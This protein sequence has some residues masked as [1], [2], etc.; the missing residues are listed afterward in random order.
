MNYQRIKK[1]NYSILQVKD[2]KV[3][4]EKGITAKNKFIA[5]FQ[6]KNLEDYWVV[7]LSM[8]KYIDSTGLGAFLILHRLTRDTG[9]KLYFFGVTG[10]VMKLFQVSKLNDLL[11]IYD[12]LEEIDNIINPKG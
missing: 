9:R 8:V 2:E 5:L 11:R 7:D 4:A 3:L 10:H 12:S 1:D 6:E